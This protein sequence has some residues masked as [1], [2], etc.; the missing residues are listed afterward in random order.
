ML[1]ISFWP[2]FQVYVL[3]VFIEELM[4]KGNWLGLEP[5]QVTAKS[6]IFPGLSGTPFFVFIAF[7]YIVKFGRNL[8]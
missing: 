2:G 7:F 6:A 4:G 1:R 5:V 3:I 8:G